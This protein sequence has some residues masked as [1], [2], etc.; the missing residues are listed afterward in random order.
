METN[1]IDLETN[2]RHDKL[3]C[4]GVETHD[5][6]RQLYAPDTVI[7]DW[8]EESL[9]PIS[10]LPAPDSAYWV[11]HNGAHFDFPKLEELAGWA[12]PEELWIDTLLLSKMHDP[13]IH[14]GHSLANLARL[15]GGAV[16]TDFDVADFDLGYT[17][18]MGAYCLDDNSAMR[19]VYYWLLAKLEKMR[20]PWRAVL[21][22]EL[23]HMV[24][25]DE[26][27]G[28][29]FMLNRERANNRYTDLCSRERDITEKLQHEWPAIT[30]RRFSDKQ[31]DEDGNWKELKPSIEEFNPGSRQQ[32]ARRL[33]SE[34]VRWTKRTETTEKGGG[35]NI[36]VNEKTLAPLVVKHPNAGL[37]LEYL[38]IGK[39]RSQIEGWLRYVDDDD[40][41]RGR[42]DTLGA[43][44][45][46]CTHSTPNLAQVKK[47]PE[48]RGCWVAPDKKIIVGVDAAGLE[49]RMLAHYMDDADYIEEV[50][51]GDVHWANACAF[52]LVPLGTARD[53]HDA[54]LEGLRDMAKTAI[55][56]LLYGA[57]DGTL[58]A[59]VGEGSK[60]GAAM[61]A[62]FESA[63]PAYAELVGKISRMAKQGHIPGLDGRRI[64]IRHQHAALNSLL[65]SAGAIIMKRSVVDG[66]RTI[67]S[68][69]YD[70][71]KL[72]CQVH[73]EIQS[74]C[75]IP[76]ADFVGQSF[77]Q[78]IVGAGEAYDMRI[79]LDGDAKVGHSWAETH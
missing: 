4:I 65:Q 22:L 74:E 41:V 34:G 20:Y 51:N 78:A 2:L 70:D 60:R 69:G 50:L 75:D 32:I 13:N 6:A 67:K 49:V 9:L 1:F 39:E 58:G 57:G 53:E 72:V 73:D 37:C 26:Q 11:A 79:P 61:R 12:V 40:R 25:T 29:G 30:H 47:G 55:Y 76:S 18:K 16:K 44:T 52:G 62:D 48:T 35:G 31:K 7:Q 66:H 24:V 33:E 43:V 36:I 17:P 15:A 64:R 28:N 59:A 21:P 5:K 77:V 38:D 54:Y 71:W 8:P 45:N 3:W 63:W 46:R 27:C 23:R 68:A 19:D 10:A 14:G 56:A 42:V